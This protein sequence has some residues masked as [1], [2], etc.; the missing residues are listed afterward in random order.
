M[1]QT[2]RMKRFGLR[3]V[4]IL[5]PLAMLALAATLFG[6]PRA[7]AR[8]LQIDRLQPQR[9]AR[10]SRE[11]RQ[12]YEQ[13]LDAIDHILYEKAI[14]L[15]QNA[16]EKDPDNEHLRLILI[17]LATYL[18]DTRWGSDSILYYDIAILNLKRMAESPLLNLREQRRAQEAIERLTALQRVVMER[19]ERRRQWGLE[20]AKLYLRELRGG[21]RD[22]SSGNQAQA[23]RPQPTGAR[24]AGGAQRAQPG[25]RG[26]PGAAGG[27]N[28]AGGGGRGGARGGR[29]GQ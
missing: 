18:G 25:L 1:R 16:L 5:A 2:Y 15:F 20:V 29:A 8:V 22:Q 13:A 11:A 21:G 17:Q 26:G 24:A 4:A 9:T 23:Q 12:D 10:M 19:D 3:R 6:V 14:K 28:V 7:E 27:Q